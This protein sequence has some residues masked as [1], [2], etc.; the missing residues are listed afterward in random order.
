MSHKSWDGAAIDLAALKFDW[1]RFSSDDPYSFR[2]LLSETK[3]FK[4]DV[5]DQ[6]TSGFGK[7]DPAAIE[8]WQKQ[9]TKVRNKIKPSGDDI[10]INEFGKEF[11]SYMGN[12]EVDRWWSRSNMFDPVILERMLDASG[13]KQQAFKFTKHWL[14]RDTRT[15]IDAKFG[16]TENNGFVPVQDEQY[17]NS[18]FEQ[19]NSSHDVVADVMR[20]QAIDRAESDLEPVNR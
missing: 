4:F 20:L 13:V 15:W 12:T 19:H 11:L 1:D 2:E 6:V 9:D 8:F 17:W 3:R 16:F 18:V 10:S 7:V 14:V 5:K